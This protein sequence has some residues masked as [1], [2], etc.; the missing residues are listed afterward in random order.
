[1]EP[2]EGEAVWEEEEVEGG[3]VIVEECPDDSGIS[4]ER[5]KECLENVNDNNNDFCWFFPLDSCEED[6]CEGEGSSEYEYESGIEETVEVSAQS[7]G[8]HCIHCIF[9]SFNFISNWNIRLLFIWLASN[10]IV[11][12]KI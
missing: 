4:N 9:F 1:M 6:S 7:D 3:I 12:K 11:R 2:G 8:K 5:S 10:P